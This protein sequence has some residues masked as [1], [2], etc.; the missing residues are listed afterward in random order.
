MRFSSLVERIDGPGAAAWTLHNAAV[1]AHGRGE[2]VIVASIGDPDLATPAPITARAVAALAAGETHYTEV[3]GRPSLRRAIAHHLSTRCAIPC[4]PDNVV[5]VAGAQNGLFSASLCLFEAGDEVILLDPAYVTYEATFSVTG[6]RPVRVAL[7]AD[8]GFRPD[9]DAVRR[10]VTPRTRGIVLTTPSNPTGVVMTA[11]E[12]DAVARLAVEH[13]LW[14]VADEVY[15]SLTFGQPHI[16]LASLP[17]MAARTVTVGSLSKSHAMTG[18][19]LGWIA[20]P[21]ALMAH[22]ERLALGMF[23]GLP[24]FIQDAALAAFD[25]YDAIT[26][27]M[28]AVYR[29]RRDLV[30]RELAGTPGLGVVSPEAGMFVLLDVRTAA[31]DPSELAWALFRATGVSVLDA[32]AFGEPARGF[33]R[34]S[35][36][37]GESELREACRRIRGFFNGLPA[38]G[39]THP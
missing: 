2:D 37:L 22:V 1:E 27:D 15:A 8:G 39:K 25:D 30:G 24:A 12:L 23:Y 5:V 20:G 6:A 35:F 7:P 38:V 26:R 17:G 11:A 10:A 36:A 31:R 34:M 16:S 19:R 28:V 29:A 3:A 18:W 13:D 32:T 4:G 33:L 14:V 9:V 21:E